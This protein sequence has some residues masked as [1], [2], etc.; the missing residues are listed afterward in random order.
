MNIQEQEAVEQ[1]RRECEIHVR[2]RHKNIVVLHCWF[3]DEDSIYLVLEHCSGGTMLDMLNQQPD[4]KLG[5]KT[6]AKVIYDVTM[7]LY[8]LRTKFE[9]PIIH[10]D[11]KPENIL[12]SR[13]KKTGEETFKLADFGWAVAMTPASVRDTLCGTTE[14]FPPEVLKVSNWVVIVNRHV[15]K[16]A[17]HF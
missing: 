1:I 12:V 14:Y 16:H 7:S 2:C 8:Y 5:E 4:Q 6:A 17:Q 10:R 3:M 15:A 11:I 9:I 13:D